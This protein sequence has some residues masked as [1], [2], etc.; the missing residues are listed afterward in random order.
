MGQPRDPQ[1]RRVTRDR[2]RR[3]AG[4]IP[5]V[6][7]SREIHGGYVG[8]NWRAI[9]IAKYFNFLNWVTVG[10]LILLG[11]LIERGGATFP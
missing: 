8:T 2:A 5:R 9:A 4:R 11:G 1:V 3:H 6:I 10:I 7:V